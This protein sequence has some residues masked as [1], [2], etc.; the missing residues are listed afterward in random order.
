[1][2]QKSIYSGLRDLEA[3]DIFH[4]YDKSDTPATCLVTNTDSYKGLEVALFKNDGSVLF[5]EVINRDTEGT[6]RKI[7]S[8]N[9][10][11]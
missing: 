9:V 1:M 3:G 6:Y 8:L 5:N 11:V 2:W 4:L 7:G 10:I